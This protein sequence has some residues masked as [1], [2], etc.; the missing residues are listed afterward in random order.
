MPCR[1]E[2]VEGEVYNIMLKPKEMAERLNVTAKTLQVW[3]RKGTLVAFRTPTNR[4]YYTEKQYLEF[5]GQTKSQSERRIVGY[6]RVSNRGQQDDLKNQVEFVRN[7]ANGKGIIL[8]EVITD[9]GSGLNYKRKKWNVLLDD[10]MANKID[11]IYVTYKDRFVR[12][13][14]EWFEQLCAKFSTKIV[15]LNN[16]DL[17]PHEELTED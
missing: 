11:T 5:T 2:T 12:F 13:G 7:Y 4:R 9:I 8:D 14:F 1:K 10:V 6:T 15:V 3:D 17:S 16:P